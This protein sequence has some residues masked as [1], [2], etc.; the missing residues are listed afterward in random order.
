ML[1]QAWQASDGSLHRTEA[2]YIH[3]EKCIE[4]DKKFEKFFTDTSIYGEIRFDSKQDLLEMV[5]SNREVF[6]WILEESK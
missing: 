2:R 4:M 6:E 3:H 5:K 1:V